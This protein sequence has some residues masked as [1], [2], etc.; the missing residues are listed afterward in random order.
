ML[1]LFDLQTLRALFAE[2]GCGCAATAQEKHHDTENEHHE[3]PPQVDVD[4]QR[5]LQSA[6][7]PDQAKQHQQAAEQREHEADGQSN[8]K[9]HNLSFLH[10]LSVRGPGCYQV[11][12]FS[13]IDFRN[14]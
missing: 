6:L 3:A 10:R 14:L 1:A 8:I 13:P 5:V 4:S 7:V 9:S 12:Q 11:R 2:F